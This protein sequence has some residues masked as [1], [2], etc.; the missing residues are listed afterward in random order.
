MDEIPFKQTYLVNSYNYEKHKL[1]KSL[2]T[3]QRVIHLNY[4]KCL[5]VSL[6]YKPFY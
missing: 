4:K 2:F 5:W 6:N 1:K 3:L